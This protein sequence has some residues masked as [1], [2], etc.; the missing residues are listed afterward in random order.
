[1]ALAYGF[2]RN[3]LLS[4]A[5]NLRIVRY[6][7]RR[8]MAIVKPSVLSS[9]CG[10]QPSQNYEKITIS[11]IMLSMQPNIQDGIQCVWR[12]RIE[13]DRADLRM[14]F[15]EKLQLLTKTKRL[16]QEE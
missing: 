12:L 4:I 10:N 16:T 14:E 1:M 8:W 2:E 15:N 7:T 11:R 5:E 9:Y 3:K 6:K 13:N